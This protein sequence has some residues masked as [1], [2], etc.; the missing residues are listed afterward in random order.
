MSTITLSR[1][2]VRSASLGRAMKDKVGGCSGSRAVTVV[3][4][5]GACSKVPVRAGGRVIKGPSVA[6]YG[7]EAAAPKDGADERVVFGRPV[8]PAPEAIRPRASVQ[9]ILK[10]AVSRRSKVIKRVAFASFVAVRVEVRAG[11]N[12][13]KGPSVACGDEAAAFD[14]GMAG[15]V[16]FGRPLVAD[17]EANPSCVSAQESLTPAVSRRSKADRKRVTWVLDAELVQAR[18]TKTEWIHIWEVKALFARA[19]PKAES[20]PAESAEPIAPAPVAVA[21]SPFFRLAASSSEA[22]YPP[23]LARRRMVQCFIAELKLKPVPFPT[24]F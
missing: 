21:V 8:A 5:S 13:T 12:A 24:L 11:D 7:N 16:I 3:R 14:E 4:R 23:P 6:T 19:L 10:L 20:P 22:R 1:I 15:L 9:G 2:P 18:S 17:P